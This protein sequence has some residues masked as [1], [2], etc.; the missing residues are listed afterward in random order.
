MKIGEFAEMNNVTTKM[1]RHYDEIGLLKPS[2]IDHSTGYRSYEAEQSH[3]INWII[4]LKNLDFTLSQIKEML[5][6]PI[7]CK[8]MIYELVRKRIEITSAINE[9]TQKKLEIDKLVK[10]LEKEGFQMDKQINLLS[11]EPNGVHEIK[12]NIPNMEMFLETAYNIS[13]LCSENDSIMVLRFDISHFKQVND[14][15]GFDV[16]DSVI[17]ACYNIINTNIGKKLSQA[18]LGRAHGDEFIIFAKAEKNEIVKIAQS[19][20]D[21]MKN[22]NFLAIGCKKQ[23]GCYIGGLISQQKTV[24]NIRN[25]IE[26]S[27]EVINQARKEGVNSVVIEPF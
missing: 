27:I 9:Q 14:D 8:K 21:D 23:M 11:I 4:I 19:I 3:Y 12:K 18:A 17:V 16:G 24:A 13:A 5:S 1:L 25:M 15:Y 6:G 10:I 7:N 22:Y 20:V 2:V 26:S